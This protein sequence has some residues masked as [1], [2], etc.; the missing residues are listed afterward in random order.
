ML[1][2]CVSSS[3]GEGGSTLKFS[4][5]RDREELITENCG[6]GG[7]LESLGPEK[8]AMTGSAR[9]WGG[10]GCCLPEEGQPGH[11]A[12]GTTGSLAE[13]VK[14]GESALGAVAGAAVPSSPPA[15]L[16]WKPSRSPSWAWG[17][18]LRRAGA[19]PPPEA[20]ALCC[21]SSSPRLPT[22]ALE[23]CFNLATNLAWGSKLL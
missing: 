22:W 8:T 5:R 6:L 14:P 17:G 4:S 1:G 16:I 23:M 3:V 20:R 21:L 7:D 13:S 12:T 10:A 9:L 2:P 15:A 11:W 19:S 18:C